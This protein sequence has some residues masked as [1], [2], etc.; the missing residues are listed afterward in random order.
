[1]SAEILL[2]TTI[3]HPPFSIKR[4]PGHLFSCT[5]LRKLHTRCFHVYRL[6]VLHALRLWPTDDEFT[7]SSPRWFVET[8]P[9]V[10]ALIP[11]PTIIQATLPRKSGENRSLL[12]GAACSDGNNSLSCRANRKQQSKNFRKKFFLTAPLPRDVAIWSLAKLAFL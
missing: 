3:P 11:E 10:T 5:L 9:R 8:P 7:L 2:Q 6:F 1:M 12:T 4:S